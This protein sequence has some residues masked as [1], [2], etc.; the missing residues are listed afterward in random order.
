MSTDSPRPSWTP[1]G[2]DTNRCQ[3]C[4]AHVSQ[5]FHRQWANN[6]GVL[7]GCPECLPRSIRFGEDVYGRSPED[8]EDF[9][10][11]APNAERDP[12]GIQQDDDAHAPTA[13]P[14]NN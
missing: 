10:G 12:G 11:D 13:A 4:S 9:D 3:R 8:V 5:S 2:T 14:P 1:S 6:Q 7:E